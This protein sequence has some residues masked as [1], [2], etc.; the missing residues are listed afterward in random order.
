MTRL[1]NLDAGAFLALAAVSNDDSQAGIRPDKD[2]H[3]LKCQCTIPEAISKVVTVSLQQT[4]CFIL[5]S[6]QSVTDN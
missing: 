6:A 4:D 3:D 2:H 5:N 1:H